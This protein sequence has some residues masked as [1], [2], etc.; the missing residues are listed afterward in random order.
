MWV[1]PAAIYVVLAGVHAPWLRLPYFWDEA[2]YFVPA[3]LDFFRHGWLLPHSTLVNGHPPGLSLWLALAWRIG[4][5][6]PVTTHLATLAAAAALLW[7]LLRLGA[8]SEGELARGSGVAAVLLCAATPLFAAQSGLAQL[9][10][11]AAALIAWALV[12]RRRGRTAACALLCVLACLTKETAI[13]APL[14]WWLVDSLSRRPTDGLARRSAPLLAA[15]S[16]LAL[17]FA[18]VRVHSGFW[19]G[20][21]SYL[22]YNLPAAHPWA[23]F[24]LALVRRLWQLAGYN[25]MWLVSGLA[26]VAVWR[27]RRRA[28]VRGS[29]RCDCLA[30]IAIYVLFHALVG[31]AVLARYLLPALALYILLAADLILRLPKAGWLVAGTAAFLVANWFWLPPYP[32]PYED[33]FAYANFVRLQQQAADAL[34]AGPASRPGSAIYT[35]WPAT[36]E[37]RNPDLGYVSRPLPVVPLT[38]FS[39]ISLAQFAASKPP[40]RAMVLLLYS[41]QEEPGSD[42][43]RWPLWRS[44]SECYFGYQPAAPPRQWLARLG[45]TARLEFRR[46][47]QWAM[48]AAQP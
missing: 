32:A 6:H 2:G 23:R 5:F 36:D 35:T 41:R 10:L 31:G 13:L 25:G 22:A 33:T 39:A 21:P 3:A 20:D 19:L 24:S 7:A 14:A 16:A 46:G 47:R 38:D 11:P 9:D 29:L 34:S 48:I 26:L 17:W 28:V 18:Y 4:G 15:G 8:E 44:W 27:D 12:W 42:W 1:A 30:L 37:L 40:T 43:S 45:L